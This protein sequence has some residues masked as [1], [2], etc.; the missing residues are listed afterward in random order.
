MLEIDLHKPLIL[1]AEPL[2][3]RRSFL[4][5]GA[6]SAA[7]LC[8]ILP[9]SVFSQTNDFWSLPRTLWLQRPA[10]NETVRETYWY[11]GKLHEPG[12]RAICMLLRDVQAGQA[13][14]MDIRLLD[15][16]RGVQGWLEA[17]DKNRPLITTSGYRTPRTNSRTEGAAQNS[18]HP[19]GQAWDGRIEGV[20]TL[21]LAK[22]GEY[23]SGGG[24]GFYQGKGFVHLDSGNLRSWRG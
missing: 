12:Y 11:D 4:K 8:G 3:S 18:K 16:L 2:A 9:P 6:L 19:R 23:L 13:V 1:D 20:S 5:A 10:S 7:T 24:V 14:A 17:Y 22:F 15:I 21:N